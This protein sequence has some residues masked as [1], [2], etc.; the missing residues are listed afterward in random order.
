MIHFFDVNTLHVEPQPAL[1]SHVTLR[2]LEPSPPPF[3]SEHRSMPDRTR[4][5]LSKPTRRSC[6][7]YRE[8][9]LQEACRPV[10]L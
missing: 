4:E 7:K 5:Q 8:V 1:D 6:R 9:L 3:W 2:S 10:W